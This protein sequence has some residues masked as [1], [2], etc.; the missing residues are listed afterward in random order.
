MKE[1]LFSI[2]VPIYNVELYIR[3]CVESVLGQQ[4]DSN[5]YEVLLIDDG[6]SD[7]C[8]SICD[9]YAQ[10]NENIKSFHKVNGGLSDARNYGIERAVG[11]YVVFLD[12]DDYLVKGSL[13]ELK[14][15][16]D[17]NGNVDIIAITTERCVNETSSI[18][19]HNSPFNKIISG[20][21]YLKNELSERVFITAW[22]S[23]YN[24][25]F[26]VKNQLFFKKG[27]I[28]EDEDFTPRAFLCAQKVI[29]TSFPVYKYIIRENS[30]TT[31]SD[32]LRNAQC[33]FEISR[34]LVEDYQ[35]LNDESLRILLLTHTAKICFKAFE[36]GK[37]YKKERRYLI[38]YC[39]MKQCS[40][41]PLERIKLALL[42]VHPGL[43]HIF[44]KMIAK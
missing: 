16:I 38:D 34:K 32:K 10:K 17:V 8:P 21:D 29:N 13:E 12:S 31:N 39:L 15:V 27:F 42:L 19:T 6:S 36:Y 24:R 4:L 3:R 2:V 37:L 1:T 30:I 41:K 25:E 43:L 35:K 44:N 18:I 23:V 11:K 7:S 9:E 40:Y 26:L 20:C 22:S 33:I 28:H 5:E 14:R